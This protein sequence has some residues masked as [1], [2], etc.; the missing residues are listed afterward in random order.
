MNLRC[1]AFAESGLPSKRNPHC[2]RAAWNTQ[3]KW[4]YKGFGGSLR[5]A[6]RWVVGGLQRP[7]MITEVGFGTTSFG[8]VTT[9]FDVEYRARISATLV[10]EHVSRTLGVNT[11]G[12]LSF[13]VKKIIVLIDG[14]YLR[15]KS[16]IAGKVYN[17]VFIERFAHTCK[18]QR[19][20]LP[21]ALLRPCPVC[22]NR[23]AAN[24]WNSIYVREQ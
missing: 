10:G 4:N 15:V 8:V 23:E 12:F 13:M 6:K 17:P 18:E 2:P 11:R 20:N 1:A 7:A 16:K 19:R 24:I 14:G 22:R 9:L 5:T 3:A 21:G